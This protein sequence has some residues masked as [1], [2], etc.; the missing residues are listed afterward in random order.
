MGVAEGGGTPLASVR[1]ECLCSER[2][3]ECEWVGLRLL[4]GC[5]GWDVLVGFVKTEARGAGRVWQGARKVHALEQLNRHAQITLG[6]KHPKNRTYRE[7]YHPLPQL[8]TL[9]VVHAMRQPDLGTTT[10]R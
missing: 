3:S 4:G 8:A 10:L 5:R 6:T 7:I 2:G 1:W 9:F